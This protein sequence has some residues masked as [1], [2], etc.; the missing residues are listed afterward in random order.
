M[1]AD[2]CHNQC[3]SEALSEVMAQEV[4]EL[5]E[6]LVEAEAKLMMVN[7]ERGYNFDAQWAGLATG[8]KIQYRRYARERLGLR[9]LRSH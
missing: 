7:L 2:G 3:P 1:T 5:R 9:D 8:Q 6:R 4:H